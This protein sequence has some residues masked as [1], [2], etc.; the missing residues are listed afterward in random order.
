MKAQNI[1]LDV[2]REIFSWAVTRAGSTPKDVL[3]R[4]P[5]F[6]Q[7]TTGEVSA[8]VK[9][10]KDF[11]KKFH[12]PFGYFFLSNIPQTEPVIPFFRAAEE[13]DAKENLY[14]QER[15]AGMGL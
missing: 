7:W 11:S 4:Y 13:D 8:T 1:R 12:F 9:Q 3:S 5:K 2:N 6:Q 10:L 14:I 15:T